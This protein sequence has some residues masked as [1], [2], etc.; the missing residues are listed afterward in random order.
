M[1]GRRVV[2]EGCGG[3]SGYHV[4][5]G[6]GLEIWS[7]VEWGGIPLAPIDGNYRNTYFDSEASGAFSTAV[8]SRQAPRSL[9]LRFVGWFAWFLRAS[10]RCGILQ[11]LAQDDQPP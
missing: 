3:T 5:G 4:D 11:L 10:F 9:T 1:W 8:V 7:G 2:A 6:V